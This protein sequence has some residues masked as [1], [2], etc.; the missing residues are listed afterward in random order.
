M[1][2]AHIWLLVAAMGLGSLLLVFTAWYSRMNLAQISP[3]PALSLADTGQRHLENFR[4]FHKSIPQAEK[5]HILDGQFT[6][7]RSTEQL[8]TRLKQAFTVIADN[9]EFLMHNPD[10]KY[11]AMIDQ[12][13][14]FRRLLF[15]GLSSGK[16]FIYYECGMSQ[17][18]STML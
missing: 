1:R 7:V 18:Y 17:H 5:E 6:V 13:L 11:P 16:W 10:W 14:L 8:P 4:R 15:A 3:P 9:Q 2:R 12:V